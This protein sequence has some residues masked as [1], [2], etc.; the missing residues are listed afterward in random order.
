MTLFEVGGCVRDEFLGLSSKDIDFSVVLDNTNMSVE[1]GFQEMTNWLESEGFKIFLSTPD[2]FTIRAKFPK[3]HVHSGLVADFVMAR[4]EVGVV[5]GTRKPILELGTL[6]DDLIRRDFTCNALA[7]DMNGVVIDLFKGVE[8]IENR[9]LDTP[10]DPMTT[11]MDDPLRMLRALRFKVTKG[12]T[13]APRVME[14][15]KQPELIERFRETVSSER[16]RE[17]L[18]KG[19]QHN[20]VEMM[21]TLV[22]AGELL[23]NFLELCFEGGVWLNPTNKKI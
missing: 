3:N 14:A 12:F 6:A 11:F 19:F 9:V 15:M 21:R 4:K 23:P 1:Q 2:C 8:A 18:K 20:S 22:E 5:E 16:I 13:I 7:K 17:E 10:L